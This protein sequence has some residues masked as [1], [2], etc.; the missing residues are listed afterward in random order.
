MNSIII[1]ILNTS[2]NKSKTI[3]EIPNK[4]KMYLSHFYVV[5]F[6]RYLS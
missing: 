6:G 5:S 4:E 1:K 2:E 3:W